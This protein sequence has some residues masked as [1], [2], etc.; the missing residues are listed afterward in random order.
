MYFME[1][2]LGGD[3]SMVRTNDT[4]AAAMVLVTD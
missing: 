3:E 1:E 4:A 2:D